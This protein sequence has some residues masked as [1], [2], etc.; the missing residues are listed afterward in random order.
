MAVIPAHAGIHFPPQARLHMDPRFRG[1]D[2]PSIPI[3][4]G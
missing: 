1:D 3:R 2:D 4:R